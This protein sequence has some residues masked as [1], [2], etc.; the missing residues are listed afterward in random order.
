MKRGLE[1]KLKKVQEKKMSIAWANIYMYLGLLD[2]P[3]FSFFSSST[4]HTSF[5][6]I[7][8]V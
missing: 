6:N 4:V 8:L 3:Q 2:T 5:E 1:L 7:R